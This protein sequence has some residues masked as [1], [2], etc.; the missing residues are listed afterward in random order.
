MV[1]GEPAFDGIHGNAPRVEGGKGANR[2]ATDS[3]RIPDD[4]GD[5]DA[6]VDIAL[7]VGRFIGADDED[8]PNFIHVDDDLGCADSVL[9]AGADDGVDG[10]LTAEH[11]GGRFLARERAGSRAEQGFDA[12]AGINGRGRVD[13]MVEGFIL[14]IFRAG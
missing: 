13:A 7:D 2:G 11:G 6:I 1:N 4:A 14:G 10:R 12:G 5:D 9:C 8:F 3:L